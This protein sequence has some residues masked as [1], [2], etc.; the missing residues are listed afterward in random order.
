MKP[1]IF[2]FFI[3]GCTKSEERI[4]RRIHIDVVYESLVETTVPGGW[5][6]G[7]IT[8][9]IIDTIRWEYKK[10]YTLGTARRDTII[11][12]FYYYRVFDSLKLSFMQYINP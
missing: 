6:N 8:G 5:C 11:F 10:P 3:F 7:D 12:P 2:I 4:P 9:H 1:F